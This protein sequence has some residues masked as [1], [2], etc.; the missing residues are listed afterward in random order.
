MT[1]KRKPRGPNRKVANRIELLGRLI[2]PPELRTTP[3]GTPFLR[4]LVDCGA[5]DG[6]LVLSVVMAGNDAR[7]VASQLKSG[8]EVRA[9]GALRTV[10]GRTRAGI[11]LAGVEVLAS[12]IT[13][14]DEP[15]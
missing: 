3:A 9:T 14:A 5:A 15:R 1:P 6:E 12:D 2:N 10:R 7:A 4:L 11:A 13:P 8:R